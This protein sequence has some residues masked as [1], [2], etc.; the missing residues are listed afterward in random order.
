MTLTFKDDVDRVKM[1]QQAKYLG[2]C[3]LKL[4]FGHTHTHTGKITLPGPLEIGN[5]RRL[6]NNES[7]SYS[8][9]HHAVLTFP[10][11]L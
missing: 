10:L 2:R 6:A 9:F 8:P 7:S 3:T 5:Y 4:L 1:N 11:T